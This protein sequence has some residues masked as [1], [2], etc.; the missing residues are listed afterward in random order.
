[1][2]ERKRVGKRERE[3]Q[4][5]RDREREREAERV[6][7]S[8]REIYTPGFATSCG[9]QQLVYVCADTSRCHDKGLTPICLQCLPLSSFP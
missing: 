7:E 1:M 8:F 2:R 4:T 9:L 3:V 6:R 5:G